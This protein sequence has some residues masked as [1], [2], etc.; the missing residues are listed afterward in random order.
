MHILSIHL[1]IHLFI[2]FAFLFLSG[3]S[4]DGGGELLPP[5]AHKG[6]DRVTSLSHSQAHSSLNA[7][8]QVIQNFQIT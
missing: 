3:V 6:S 7:H 4:G 5:S 8:L 2:L 1:S